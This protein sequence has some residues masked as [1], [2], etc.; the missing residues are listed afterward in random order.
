MFFVPVNYCFIILFHFAINICRTCF[1]T[2]AFAILFA[3]SDKSTVLP[4][5]VVLPPARSRLIL[6]VFAPDCLIFC[7]SVLTLL[8]VGV[9][10]LL[11]GFLGVVGLLDGSCLPGL[12]GAPLVF[13]L[14]KFFAPVSVGSALAGSAGAL[15]GLAGVCVSF[16]FSYDLEC[17]LC[18][19]ITMMFVVVVKFPF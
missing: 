4:C 12:V 10:V 16:V 8:C 5:D 19:I 17:I 6:S 13:V 2:P 1:C 11:P 15:V 18:L 7:A 9:A 3:K 14:S